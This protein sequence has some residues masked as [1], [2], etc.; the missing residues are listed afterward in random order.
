MENI[1]DTIRKLV[2][3]AESK[4]TSGD[5]TTLLEAEAFM[6][7]AEELMAKHNIDMHEVRK[8][9]AANS[10]KFAH[11]VYGERI[12]TKENLAGS[13][14]RH[15]LIKMLCDHNL[16]GVIFNAKGEKEGFRV[17][18]DMQN[19]EVTVWLYNYLDVTLMSLAKAYR[20][21]LDSITRDVLGCRHTVLKSFIDG[22]I[23]GIS[24]KLYEQREQSPYK[25]AMW[26]VVKYN[27]AALQEY[28]KE[29]IKNF[30]SSKSK[31]IDI[32]VDSAFAAGVEAGRAVQL[33]GRRLATG[34][35]AVKTKLLK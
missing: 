17:Y 8:A 3:T 30:V 5:P 1:L 15:D 29:K 24:R 28:L 35:E 11:W 12:Y 6:Q 16:T 10:D 26:E 14:W 18:G 33:T 22:A 23:T 19:V 9:A 4:K 32:K 34:E 13:R 21:G 7:K 31:S 2:E 25:A 20:A 27:D